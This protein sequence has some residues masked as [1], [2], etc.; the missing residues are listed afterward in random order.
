MA[1]QMDDEMSNYGKQKP[2]D[3]MQMDDE[4]ANYR[5]SS[6][7]KR[8]VFS[9]DMKDYRKTDS[10]T[11]EARQ[12]RE[13][14]EAALRREQER[15]ER[16]YKREQDKVN[17]EQNRLAAKER[18]EQEKRDKKLKDAE[19]SAE[20]IA[21]HQESTNRGTTAKDFREMAHKNKSKKQYEPVQPITPKTI[22]KKVSDVA[23][24]VLIATKKEIQSDGLGRSGKRA[25]RAYRQANRNYNSEAKR[26]GSQV[27]SPGN[28]GSQILFGTPKTPVRS[29][30]KGMT[31][32]SGVTDPLSNFSSKTLLGQQPVQQDRTIEG[33]GRR[34]VQNTYVPKKKKGGDPLKSFSK[35]IGGF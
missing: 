12:V 9:N 27:A 30:A 14:E 24:G 26:I 8:E 18:R 32:F 35:M 3:N 21:R 1:L 29:R 5:G 28:Y 19:E 23:G 7:N 34:I 10:D 16:D 13:V 11:H 4:M 31:Q 22:V 17:R 20:R 25:S 2:Q 6:S 15:A 33:M